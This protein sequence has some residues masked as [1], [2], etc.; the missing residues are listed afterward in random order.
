MLPSSASCGA[1]PSNPNGTPASSS[2]T[3]RLP[4]VTSATVIAA[5]EAAP[6][7]SERHV[8]FYD[9]D[10]TVLIDG[11]YVIKGVPGRILFSLLSENAESGRTE[12]SNREIRLDRSIG[13]PAG[14]ITVVCRLWYPLALGLAM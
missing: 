9:H 8:A 3:S 13:L 4:L 7:E 11:Q 10:G 2:R 6:S 5:A 14:P 12:F 1:A